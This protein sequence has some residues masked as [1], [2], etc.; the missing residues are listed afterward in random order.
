MNLTERI[1]A[2][3]KQRC[4]EALHRAEQDGKPLT[5]ESWRGRVAEKL[6][7]NESTFDNWFFGENAPSLPAIEKLIVHFGAAFRDEIFPCESS[8][9]PTADDVLDDLT[10]FVRI[11]RG[12]A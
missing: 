6:G 12:G 3:L 8:G 7:E 5:K 10:E 2:A 11:R 4:H 9:G 1:K